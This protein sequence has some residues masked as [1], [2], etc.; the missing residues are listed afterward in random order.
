MWDIHG[1]YTSKIEKIVV[2]KEAEKTVFLR[3]KPHRTAA[4]RSTPFPIL[5]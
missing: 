5:A 4:I 2:Q 3:E 1:L